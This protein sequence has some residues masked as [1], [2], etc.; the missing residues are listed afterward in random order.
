MGSMSNLKL[1]FLLVIFFCVGSALCSPFETNAQRL[2]RG[3]PPKP[4]R[5]RRFLGRGGTPVLF[6]RASASPSP[7]AVASVTLTGRLQVRNPEDGS[8]LGNVRNWAT[9]GTISGVNSLSNGQDLI[10]KFSYNPSRPS[11]FN[12]ISTNAAFPAPFYVGAG[13]AAGSNP[14]NLAVG[15]RDTVPFTNV[16]LSSGPLEESA[17]W[18]IDPTTKKLTAR[19]TNADGSAAPTTLVY[20]IRENSLF[21]VGD[22]DA[23]NKDNDTPASPIDLFLVPF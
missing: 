22:I 8:V 19:W 2:A 18:F 11:G 13:I 17:I 3:L 5:F 14:P 16:D 21:F 10:V 1:P 20:D 15:S 9:G 7:S 4:P 12:I 6:A 23:Y